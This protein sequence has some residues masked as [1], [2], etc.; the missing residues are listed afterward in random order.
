MPSNRSGSNRR[1]THRWGRRSS[2]GGYGRMKILF[3]PKLSNSD[4]TF[5]LSPVRAAMT[6]VTDATPMTM[7]I[8]V[9]MARTLLAQ[10]WPSARNALCQATLKRD[11]GRRRRNMGGGN[12]EVGT[13]NDERR[14]TNDEQRA[15][16]R[17]GGP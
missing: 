1:S 12:D 8:V 10:I 11:R 7:P 5:C 6:A 16:G 9:R 2:G 15:A 14:T 4:S 13:M 3:V 17:Q